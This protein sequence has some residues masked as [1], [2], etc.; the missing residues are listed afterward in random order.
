MTIARIAV[1][2]AAVVVGG[3]VVYALVNRGARSAGQAIAETAR[4]AVQAAQTAVNPANPDNVVNRI[5]SAASATV[6]G[7]GSLG[8]DAYDAWNSVR[9]WF[10]AGDVRADAPAAPR[11]SRMPAQL[12]AT[13]GVGDKLTRADVAWMNSQL[14]GADVQTADVEDAE[15][16]QFM[17]AVNTSHAAADRLLFAVKP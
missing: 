6:G 15:Q 10:G 7:S 9:S 1:G 3:V 2:V 12:R 11:A 4:A 14:Y 17:R 13:L 8:S 5:A 16:G